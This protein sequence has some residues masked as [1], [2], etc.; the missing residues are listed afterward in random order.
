MAVSMKNLYPAFQ[1]A[2]QKAYPHVNMVFRNPN[3]TCF[4]DY[5]NR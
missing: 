1:G 2:G 4:L 5:N 3:R